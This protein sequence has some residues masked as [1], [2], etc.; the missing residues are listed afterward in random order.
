MVDRNE[1]VWLMVMVVCRS[2]W[3]SDVG[4]GSVWVSIMVVQRVSIIVV[5]WVSFLVVLWVSLLVLHGVFV[6]IDDIRAV[7]VK[8]LYVRLR[9]VERSGGVLYMLRMLWLSEKKD[10]S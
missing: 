4:H 3:C 5:Q 9:I 10:V 6:A 1:W 7:M 8:S 2:W